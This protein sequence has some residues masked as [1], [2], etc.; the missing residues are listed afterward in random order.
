L[1]GVLQDG[2]HTLLTEDVALGMWHN[3]H[4]PKV[5]QETAF[6]VTAIVKRE[7][8]MFKATL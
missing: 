8:E 1:N 6:V 5:D 3:K 7:K 2:R 4:N